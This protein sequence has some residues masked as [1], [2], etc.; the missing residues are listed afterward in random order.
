MF[1]TLLRKFL[2]VFEIDFLHFHVQFVLEDFLDF[3]DLLPRQ[4]DSFLHLR[5]SSVV[6]ENQSQFRGNNDRFHG[7]VIFFVWSFFDIFVFFPLFD[8]VFLKKSTSDRNP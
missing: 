6:T 3:S 4:N 8:D 1:V 5:R 7:V 2:S